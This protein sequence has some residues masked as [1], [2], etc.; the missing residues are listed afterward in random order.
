MP[1]FEVLMPIYINDSAEAVRAALLSIIEQSL[2]PERV[3]VVFDGPVAAEVQ[4]VVE[5]FGS[6]AGVSTTV[7]RLAANAGLGVALAEGL[8]LCRSDLV[9]RMD[10][11]DVSLPSRF[12]NQMQYFSHDPAL[13]VVGSDILEFDLTLTHP[14]GARATPELHAEILR[15]MDTRNPFNHMS[16]MFRREAVIDVGNY[17]RCPFF[18]DYYLW[19]RLRRQGYSF[20]NTGTIEVHV[21]GGRAMVLRR[22]GGGYARAT[23]RFLMTAAREH[24]LPPGA[25]VK[26]ALI[27]L[28][29]AAAPPAVRH[30]LYSRLLR[31]PTC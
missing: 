15:A 1:Q 3:I 26:Q 23:L 4:E 2:R 7:H 5:W 18:E 9:A 14:E 6:T 21:R 30:W 29:V 11:D 8:R 28:P 13:A 12:A 20:A 25:V 10:A 24:L 27:R 17:I 19:L 22:G 16:V 31:V